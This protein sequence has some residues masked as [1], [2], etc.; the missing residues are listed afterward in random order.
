MNGPSS[1]VKVKT[2]SIQKVLDLSRTT[3]FAATFW[4]RLHPVSREEY[5]KWY[6]LHGTEQ[7][8]TH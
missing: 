3:D 6:T 4:N 1:K 7:W 2:L 5:Q 8:T